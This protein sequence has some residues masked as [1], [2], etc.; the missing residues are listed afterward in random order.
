MKTTL[1]YPRRHSPPLPPPEE[2]FQTNKKQKNELLLLTLLH[3]DHN[4]VSSYIQFSLTESLLNFK[5]R[6]CT[7]VLYKSIG[8]S[9]RYQSIGFLKVLASMLYICICSPF[10]FRISFCT[11]V[12]TSTRK[13]GC[14]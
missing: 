7:I 4:F 10:A 11:S 14:M 13:T 2:V 3:F 5:N 1:P 6:K 9:T 8:D 12:R